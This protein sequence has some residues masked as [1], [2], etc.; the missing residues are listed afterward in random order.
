MTKT[1]GIL[2]YPV[3][4]S[5]SPLMHNTAIAHH[6]L[7]MRYLPFEVLPENL[8]AAIDGIRALGIHGVSLTIPHKEAVIPLLDVIDPEA[9]KMG[10]VN[11]ICNVS[12]TLTGYNTDGRG[13]IES[14]KNDASFFPS[15][16]NIVILGAGGAAKGV[17]SALF[18]AGV[19]T[20]KNLFSLLGISWVSQCC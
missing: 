5:L 1:L 11:T 17:A 14:L 7:D 3:S 6:G 20:V 16:K 15:G 4:H 9:K 2:G 12:G 13:F 8:G 10:A 18:D 19:S